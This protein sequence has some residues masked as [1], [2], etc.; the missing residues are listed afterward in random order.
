VNPTTIDGRQIIAHSR[1]PIPAHLP[2]LHIS[3]LD[4]VAV[5]V[6]EEQRVV[7]YRAI[8]GA[9][10]PEPFAW[11]ARYGE[12]VPAAEVA[13]YFPQGPAVTS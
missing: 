6:R 5:L 8:C 4:L 13:V 3:R 10:A 9:D 11:T 2:H 1:R 12:A 7:A